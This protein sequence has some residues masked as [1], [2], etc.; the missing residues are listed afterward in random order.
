MILHAKRFW[1]EAITPMLWPFDISTAIDLENEL[2]LDDHGRS[3]LQRLM[4]TDAPIKLRDH[5]AWGCP[6]HVLEIKVQSSA[7][8]LPK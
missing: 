2:S 7:K 3:P 6:V 4:A 8:G 1:P 5:H